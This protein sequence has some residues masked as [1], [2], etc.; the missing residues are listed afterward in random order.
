MAKAGTIDSILIVGGGTAGWMAAAYL[1]KF[2]GRRPHTITLVESADIGTIGVGEATIPTLIRFIRNMGFDESEF[3]RAC[4]ATYKLGI[5]FAGWAER[6]YWHPFGVCGS[7]IDNLD[8][9]AGAVGMFVNRNKQAAQGRIVH[10]NIIYRELDILT[11]FSDRQ[12]QCHP[13]HPALWVIANHDVSAI[14]RNFV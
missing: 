10:Q 5:K 11:F 3:M 8:I 1:H 4:H 7:I 13:I 6:D 2:L 9:L 12:H 14:L